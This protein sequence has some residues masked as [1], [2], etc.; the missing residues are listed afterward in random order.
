VSNHFTTIVVCD[1][2]YEVTDGELPNVLCMVAYLLDENLRHVRTIKRWRGEF[3]AEPSFDTGPNTLFVAYSA[4]AELTCFLAL[5]WKFP[6][7]I[8]DCH[9]AYLAASN[10]LRPYNPDEVYKRQRKRLSDACRAYDIPGWEN[11][12]KETM[13]RDIGE[14]R[15]RDYG[16]DVVYEY[17]EEDVKKTAELLAAQLRKGRNWLPAPSVEQI[18]CAYSPALDKRIAVKVITS[19]TPVRRRV[20][21]V[22]ETWAPIPH[23]LGL[24]L[25]K[26]AGIPALAVLLVLEIAIHEARCNRVRLTNDLLDRYGITRQ[27][28]GRWLRQIAAAGVISVEWNGQ[29]APMVTHHWY[30]EAGKLKSS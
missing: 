16:Q 8:F 3:G 15:W 25:A 6:K 7:H 19:G 27:S 23:H 12:D 17:C 10:I 28:K 29:E 14:G 1:F 13:A 9:T 20:A 24:E 4:W 26:R 22:T 18:G 21:K 30:T 5:G 11:I 2:E